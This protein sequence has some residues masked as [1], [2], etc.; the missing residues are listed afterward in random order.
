MLSDKD[1]LMHRERYKDIRREFESEALVRQAL[2]GR[3]KRAP[4]VFRG[5]VALGNY[6]H[7]A[8]NWVNPPEREVRARPV[9][10]RA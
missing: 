10:R 9:R 6:L 7:G 4:L 3:P 2:A 5:I 1:Y 8:W